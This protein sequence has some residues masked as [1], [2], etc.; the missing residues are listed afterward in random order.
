MRTYVG[1]DYHRKYSYLTVMDERGQ[2][3][4]QGTVENQRQAVTRFLASDD[5]AGYGVAVLE[6]TRNWAVMHDWLDGLVDEVHLAHPQKVKAIA[7]AK[8]KTDKID[9]RGR[10]SRILCLK[11]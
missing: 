8:I 4:R 11:A 2:V 1:V 5:G 3:L 7:E 6:A 10:L 9:A